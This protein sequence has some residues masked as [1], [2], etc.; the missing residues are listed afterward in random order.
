[1][2]S[3]GDTWNYINNHQQRLGVSAVW[4]TVFVWPSA[5][6]VVALYFQTAPTAGYVLSPMVV[7]LTIANALVWSIWQLNGKQG[8]LPRVDEA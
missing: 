8:L 4:N 1:M 3:I 5:A 7:W 6:C 2:Q